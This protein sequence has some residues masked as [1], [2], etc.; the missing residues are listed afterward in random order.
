MV[1]LSQ[2]IFINSLRT[3]IPQYA[4]SVNAAMVIAAG[5]TRFRQILPREAVAGV[6]VAYGKSLGRIYYLTAP[7]AVVS[8]F[9]SS[10]MGWRDLRRKG[11]GGKVVG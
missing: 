4:P 6:L 3:T 8:L 5:G 1:V 11:T 9:F 7:V 2:T 10:F